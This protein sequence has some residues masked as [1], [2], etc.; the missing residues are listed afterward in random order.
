MDS[1][2]EKEGLQSS[3]RKEQS[4]GRE[5]MAR[6]DE[7]TPEVPSQHDADELD[8]TELA[9]DDDDDDDLDIEADE[10]VTEKEAE[11]ADGA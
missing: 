6:E 10:E 1:S 8:E 5:R 3:G 7:G 4:V 2:A 9:L 11:R